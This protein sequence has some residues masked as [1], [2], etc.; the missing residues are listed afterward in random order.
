MSEMDSLRISSVLGYLRVYNGIMT[1]YISFEITFKLAK[2][3]QRL[4][5]SFDQLRHSK[6]SIQRVFRGYS[7]RH[8]VLL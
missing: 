1:P 7:L 4:S 2:L 8:L 3:S 6:L 5:K